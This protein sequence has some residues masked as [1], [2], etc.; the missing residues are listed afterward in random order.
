MLKLGPIDY[1]IVL[2]HS[3]EYLRMVH[4]A[5]LKPCYPTAGDWDKTGEII[6]EES[7]DKDFPGFSKKTTKK[8]GRFA[9]QIL[10]R[11]NVITNQKHLLDL[12]F[13]S[14]S[15]KM[16]AEVRVARANNRKQTGAVTQKC[17][18]LLRNRRIVA[19]VGVIKPLS[20]ALSSRPHFWTYFLDLRFGF[21]ELTLILSSTRSH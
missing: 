18:C 13:A 17:S 6:E 14:F 21:N 5:Q 10:L 19:P 8:T 16:K 4:V 12:L 1:E 15:N 9:V 20:A 7:E 11:T 3:S 2:E